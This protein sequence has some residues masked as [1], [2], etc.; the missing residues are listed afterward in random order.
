M[1]LCHYYACLVPALLLLSSCKTTTK[2]EVVEVEKPVIVEHLKTDTIKVATER[3]DSVYLRDSIIVIRQ[4]DTVY[5]TKTKFEY[6]YKYMWRDSIRTIHDST[7]KIVEV[8]VPKVIEVE[9]PVKYVP[10]GL[11]RLA[12]FG[13]M[14]I[15][16][17]IFLIYSKLKS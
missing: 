9:K 13:G 16:I 7:P 1:K 2:V 17:F 11:K 15:L 10:K 6:R 12:I 5:I 3:T 8:E 14:S 4:A